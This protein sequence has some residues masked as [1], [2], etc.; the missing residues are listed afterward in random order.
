MKKLRT[1]L[2]TTLLVTASILIAQEELPTV[3]MLSNTTALELPSKEGAAQV[4]LLT[5]LTAVVTTSYVISQDSLATI[6]EQVL[7]G[8]DYLTGCMI[9]E[10]LR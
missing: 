5:L 3:S 2:F 10:F 9:T 1:L 8:V 7:Q 6:G 4:T